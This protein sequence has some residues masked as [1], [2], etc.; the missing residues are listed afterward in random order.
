[1][2]IDN[3]FE[4]AG[5]LVARVSSARGSVGSVCYCPAPSTKQGPG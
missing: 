2:V 5:P 3:D 1:M 4:I